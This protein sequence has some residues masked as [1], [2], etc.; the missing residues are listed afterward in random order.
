[1]TCRVGLFQLSCLRFNSAVGGRLRV[2][3]ILE[4]L[5]LCAADFFR[6]ILVKFGGGRGY[7]VGACRKGFVRDA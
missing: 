6:I 3:Q 4:A 5:G 2:K 7:A 1:M